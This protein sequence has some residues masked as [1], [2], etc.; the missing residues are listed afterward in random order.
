[1]QSLSH[2]FKPGARRTAEAESKLK[3]AYQ[4]VFTGKPS[5]QDQEI[6]LS[7]LLSFGDLFTVALPDENL[8]LREG[9]RQ[10]AYRIFRFLELADAEQMATAA[11]AVMETLVSDAEGAV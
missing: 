9:R 10:M 2:W 1:M 11:A 8:S 7:D 6:V 4:S 3:Q 5:K